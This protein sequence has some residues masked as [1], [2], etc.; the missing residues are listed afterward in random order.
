MLTHVWI[1][2]S[3]FDVVV[4][5]IPGWV[6]GGTVHTKPWE[7]YD[8]YI[9]FVRSEDELRILDRFPHYKSRQFLD[10]VIE[11]NLLKKYCG[12]DDGK[13]I[14]DLGGGYGR[15]AEFVLQLYNVNYI[16]VEAVPM[17]LLVAPQ[18]I[19]AVLG[20]NVNSY[21]DDNDCH[22]SNFPFSVYPTHKL[23]TL[24]PEA[25]I[26]INIHSTQEMGNEKTSF[27]LKLFEMHKSNSA[28][29]FLKNN[30]KYI[31]RKWN[32]PTSWKILYQN[33][34]WPCSEGLVDGVFQ[35]SARTWVRVFR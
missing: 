5:G 2:G 15:L 20:C 35:D 19:K 7:H 3:V 25:D 18:Y 10:A 8:R 9:E 23:E 13:V 12:L 21:Y 28:T 16:E 17:S 29:V 6:G 33:L 14:I 11:I 1:P 26:L 34:E 22:F 4:D 31:T 27:Y 30:F 24:I 32:F